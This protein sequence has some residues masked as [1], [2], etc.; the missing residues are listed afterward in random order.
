MKR[1]YGLTVAPHLWYEKF[2]SALLDMDFTASIHDPCLL[3][4][5]NFL[6]IMCMDD[7]G[8]AAPSGDIIDN[9]VTN[10]KSCGVKLTKKGTISEYLGIKFEEDKA[11][12]TITFTQKGLIQKVLAALL[13]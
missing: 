10:L 5:K 12:G 4:K 2:V 13:A 6:V 11:T 9:F 8:A 7:V 1:Q 3:Y